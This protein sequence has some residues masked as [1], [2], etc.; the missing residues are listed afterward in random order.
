[1]S[2][3]Q[4]TRLHHAGQCLCLLLT[5]SSAELKPCDACFLPSH[6]LPM[7][8]LDDMEKHKFLTIIIIFFGVLKGRL[9]EVSGFW[10]SVV[11]G[12]V[13]LL[14]IIIKNSP[15]KLKSNI[16]LMW[17]LAFAL[18]TIGTP[19]QEEYF[20]CEQHKKSKMLEA[21]DIRI[22]NPNPSCLMFLSNNVS[23]K[24][25]LNLAGIIQR[26]HLRNS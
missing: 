12:L 21:K 1:M 10:H 20:I 15:L 9:F 5:F 11:P 6:L 2:W 17:F 26:E 16:L 24:L 14:L 25:L 8:K 4:S 13:V 19:P 23:E 18:E 22:S 7:M 3:D